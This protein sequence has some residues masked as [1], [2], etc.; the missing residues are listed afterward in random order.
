MAIPSQIQPLDSF[1]EGPR[2]VV[3]ERRIWGVSRG[4]WMLLLALALSSL[5]GAVTLIFAHDG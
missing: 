2:Q 5:A 4:N 3:Q 1:D